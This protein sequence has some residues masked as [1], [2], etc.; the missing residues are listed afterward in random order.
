MRFSSISI[1]FKSGAKIQSILTQRKFRD[2]WG[3]KWDKNGYLG[4]KMP[5]LGVNKNFLYIFW[6]EKSKIWGE[7]FIPWGEI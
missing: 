5:I 3:E 1:A 7:N 2:E 4:V 6:G